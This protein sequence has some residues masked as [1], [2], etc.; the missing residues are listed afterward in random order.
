MRYCYI[1]PYETKLL[2][3]RVYG[4]PA[5]CQLR[6]LQFS[7]FISF[8]VFYHTQIFFSTKSLY[9]SSWAMAM[10]TETVRESIHLAISVYNV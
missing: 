2:L 3:N 5:V 6:I 4:Q 7:L 9:K 1:F 10:L 8:K